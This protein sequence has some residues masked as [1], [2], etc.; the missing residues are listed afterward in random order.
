MGIQSSIPTLERKALCGSRVK[1]AAT[2][3]RVL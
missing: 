2:L 1:R 3:L